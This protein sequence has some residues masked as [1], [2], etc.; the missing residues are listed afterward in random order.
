MAR[1]AGSSSSGR[2]RRAAATSSPYSTSTPATSTRVSPSK[3]PQQGTP[4]K[5]GRPLGSKNKPKPQPAAAE[6]EHEQDEQD[7]QPSSAHEHDDDMQQPQELKGEA[8]EVTG[9]DDEAKEADQVCPACRVKGSFRDEARWVECDNCQKWYHWS[10]VAPKPTDKLEHV[11][12]VGLRFLPKLSP[13][14]VLTFSSLRQ[15][16]C[17]TCVSAA[18]SSATPLATTYKPTPPSS[19][20]SSSSSTPLRK[21]QRSTRSRVDYA[22]LDQ[23]L[24]ASVDRWTKVI[25]TRESEGKIVDGFAPALPGGGGGGGGG[26]RRMKASEI[27]DEWVYRENGMTEP[28]VVPDP[29]GLGMKMPEGGITVRDV[30]ELVGPETPLEVIDCASQSS[31][32]N[33]NLGQWADYYDDPRRDKVRNVISLEVSESRLGRMVVAPELVRKLDWVDNVWP[34]DMKEPGTYPRV[35]KYCLMS[36]ERCWTDWHIDF[37]GSSVFYHIL[38]GGKT[39]YFIRP[40]P[41]NLAAYERWSGSTER[42]EQHWLGDAC[43][44]VYKMELKPG[45][46]AFI[47]TGWI[48]A[49][50]TPADSLVI[51]GNFLH[52]LNIP[53]QLRVYQIELATKVPRK[54]RYPHFVRLL[55]L[56]AWHYFPLFQAQTLPPTPDKPLPPSLGAPRVLTGLRQLSSFLIEQTQRFAKG[57]QVS[58]E[59]RRLARE[60]IP[61]NKIADPVTLSREFRK[62][63]LKACGEEPDAEC[64]LP[65]V[66][67]EPPALTSTPTNGDAAGGVA[68]AG[69]KRKAESQEGTPVPSGSR[70]GAM[71]PPPT[72]KAKIKHASSSA[73]PAPTPGVGSFPG[74]PAGTTA[75][76][77]LPPPPGGAYPAAAEQIIGRHTVPVVQQT[78]TEERIDPSLPQF[79]ARPADVRES[80]STQSVVRR[81]ERDPADPTGAGGPVVETRTTITIVERVKWPASGSR[82]PYPGYAAQQS[83]YGSSSSSPNPAVAAASPHQPQGVGPPYAAPLPAG[84]STLTPQQQQHQARMNQAATGNPAPYPA[85]GW[86]YHYNLSASGAAPVAPVQPQPQAP[87]QPQPQVQTSAYAQYAQQQQQQQYA[88]VQQAQQAQ[89]VQ[90]V[91][92]GYP[93]PPPSAVGS[94]SSS[95]AAVS[96]GHQAP[97]AR[98]L[99]HPPH[100]QQQQQQQ[101]QQG[102]TPQQ[103]FS[104]PPLPLPPSSSSPSSSSSAAGMEPR[105]PFSAM[106][107]AVGLQQQQQQQGYP[108]SG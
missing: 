65:H 28:F 10:C 103:Q 26:F 39:F 38:R 17:P 46:T 84:Q 12:K 32:N 2:P 74:Y 29:E 1:A 14:T 43:D 51:G 68:A 87:V 31:L 7:G 63:V 67:E 99:S 6:D 80:R 53:T 11:D 91:P 101:Q 75:L 73:S 83:P 47:P 22:N 37:A 71:L 79:G 57:A 108:G 94:S 100:Q 18:A 61:W 36:V 70:E 40:T 25:S 82:Q 13:L 86:P 4:K 9:A 93:P 41:A 59:R 42:Q 3:K 62:V 66:V 95:S 44:V 96:V 69:T 90:Q 56:V 85:A 16:F 78:R 58:P 24:P 102:P 33:W 52:S 60:N 48:H 104:L 54:F 19:A 50:Y 98:R 77:H 106:M 34:S 27:T 21:S 30:A 72:T 5:R 88:A 81:Y 45:N 105:P 49:V 20:R 23:H 55:W 107:G 97:T 92:Y 89:T 8:T 35:Q 15:F 64:F 76:S